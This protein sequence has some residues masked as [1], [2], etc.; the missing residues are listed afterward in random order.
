MS[1]IDKKR[2][3]HANKEYKFSNFIFLDSSMIAFQLDVNLCFFN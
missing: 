1:L 3:G 2:K